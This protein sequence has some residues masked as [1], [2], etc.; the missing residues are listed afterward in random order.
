MGSRL[1]HLA[2]ADE[3]EHARTRGVYR[4]STIG[5]S[6]DDEGFIHCSYRHQV[7]QTASLFY[8]GRDDVLVLVID[9]ARLQAPVRVEGGFPHVYGELPVDAVVEVVPLAQFEC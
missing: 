5:R 3:W 1:Y 8:G 2:L 6:I 7:A 4:R 9:P